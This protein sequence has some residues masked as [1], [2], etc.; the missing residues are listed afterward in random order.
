M[1]LMIRNQGIADHEAFTLLGVS[2][3]R[4]INRAGT[5]GQFGSGSKHGVAVFL[6]KSINPVIVTGNLKMEFYS[7]PKIISGQQFDQICVKYSGKDIDGTS[8]TASADLGWTLQWGTQ[9]WTQLSMGFR[10]FVS[11]A[12]DGSVIMGGSYKDV[13]IEVVDK[14][15]AKTG[16]TAVF[17][18][19]TPEVQNIWKQLGTLFLHY[20]HPS[21]LDRKILPKI[22]EDKLLIYK[23][24]VLVSRINTLSAFDYNL[25]DELTLDESRNAQSWDV[26]YAVSKAMA[27]AEPR[28][29]AKILSLQLEDKPLWEDELESSYLYEEDEDN[30]ES[31]KNF[32]AAFTALAGKDGVL[33]SGTK[34]ISEFVH[35]KGFK[36]VK[37]KPNW[38]RALEL[39]G[40]PTETSVLDGLEKEGMEETEATPDMVR[41]VDEVW[42]LLESHDMLNGRSKPQIK[43]FAPLMSA[44]AQ[45]WG[46][47][48]S[49]TVYLHKE[50]GNSP[51][52]YKVAL[53][54]CCHHSSGAGD[55][56]RDMQDFLF[57]LI[58]KMWS[59]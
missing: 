18:P 32:H 48:K 9:D 13:E 12:I 45:T 6:R 15:R 43:S 23:K 38:F 40:V 30:L 25:G 4:G 56:S 20:S 54:E 41:I 36:P 50:L 27:K 8:K 49:G 3:T 7:K 17:L 2:T 21:Y 42:T 24:G 47:Y 10:E 11:N 34:T 53:E 29:I 59:K 57:R 52:M 26:R 28:D 14:P 58:C 31:K 55:M 51:L 16:H 44:E 19:F 33:S 22:S 5:V 1:Y 46:L 39:Y 37:V 35:R